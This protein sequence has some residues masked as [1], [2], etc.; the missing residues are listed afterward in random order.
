M[1]SSGQ[2]G[3]MLMAEVCCSA[4]ALHWCW[5]SLDVVFAQ[6][7]SKAALLLQGEWGAASHPW[8]SH[9]PTPEQAAELASHQDR[10]AASLGTQVGRDVDPC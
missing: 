3:T 7:G 4:V 2:K 10:P 8:A 6:V 1:K 9:L 5:K